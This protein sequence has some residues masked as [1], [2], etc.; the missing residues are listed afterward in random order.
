MFIAF[1]MENNKSTVKVIVVISLMSM[2]N[3]IV[4]FQDKRSFV[5]K[6]ISIII[7]ESEIVSFVDIN[8]FLVCIECKMKLESPIGFKNDII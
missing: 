1:D 2:N 8:T 5:V 6:A 3:F 7:I 4:K